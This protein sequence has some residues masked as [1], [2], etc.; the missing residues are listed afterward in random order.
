MGFGGRARAGQGRREGGWEARP[1]GGKNDGLSCLECL[2]APQKIPPPSAMTSSDG[3][4]QWSPHLVTQG[5][6]SV[7]RELGPLGLQRVGEEV[8]G[9]EGVSPPQG[10]SRVCLPAASTL[11]PS[12]PGGM[13]RS[14]RDWA[15]CLGAAPAGKKSRLC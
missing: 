5:D 6:H 2:S 8:A 7:A 4:P 12:G 14:G 13:Q 3:V 11:R 1:P 9:K 15:Q 10:I